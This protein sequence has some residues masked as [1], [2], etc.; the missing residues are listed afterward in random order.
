MIR[1]TYKAIRT[2]TLLAKLNFEQL[3]YLKII[4]TDNINSDQI[5]Y[6][7]LIKFERYCL[8]LQLGPFIKGEKDMIQIKSLNYSLL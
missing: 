6:S 3:C 2:T 7:Y 5:K 8:I 1:K 4:K